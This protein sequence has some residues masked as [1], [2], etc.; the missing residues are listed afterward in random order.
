V[1]PSE[2]SA[3]LVG[4]DDV[5]FAAG[6]DQLA[7]ERPGWQPVHEGL[8]AARR[9]LGAGEPL[10]EAMRR[11]APSPHLDPGAIVVEHL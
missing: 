8:L 5:G 6:H 7:A 4:R 11:D 10:P 2:Y 9:R 3:R 1:R